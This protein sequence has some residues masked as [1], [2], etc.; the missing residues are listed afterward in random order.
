[1]KIAAVQMVSTPR[2]ET[3]LETARRLVA[4]AAAEGAGLVALPE[5]FCFMG[6]SDRD[7]LAI[8]EAPGGGPIQRMLAETARKHRV[9]LIGGTLPLTLD[10]AARRAGLAIDRVM[11]ADL[12][13]SPQGELAARYDKIHLFAYDNGHERYDEGRTLRA[14][15]TPVAFDADG[16]RVG[17]SVCYDLRFPELYR[18]LMRPPCDL[19][20]VPSAFTHT[21]GAAH[22]EV[23]LRARA[24]ENQ[25]YV[26]AAAQ[27]GTHENGR[28]TFGHSLIVDPWGEVV[29]CREEGEGVVVAELSRERIESVRRQLPALEHRRTL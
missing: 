15:A 3:N 27:G 8:A 25:C 17:L 28:R 23:L 9:W 5:Y 18:A 13:F 7:K 29:A 19:L 4:R 2:V 1:M 22:W 21:T 24:I 16:V 14:G 10:D 26:I 12:V 11:N 6:Q 20:S